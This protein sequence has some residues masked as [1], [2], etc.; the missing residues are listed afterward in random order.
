VQILDDK[1]SGKREFF[2][3]FPAEMPWFAAL[4]LPYLYIQECR[5]VHKKRHP[6]SHVH[7]AADA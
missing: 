7:D 5:V 1:N 6:P 2:L 4:A 3:I